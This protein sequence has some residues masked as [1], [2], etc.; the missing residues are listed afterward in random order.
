MPSPVSIS[1]FSKKDL[2]L[3]CDREALPLRGGPLVAH[4]LRPVAA[5]PRTARPP[6]W[7][8]WHHW[9]KSHDWEGSIP[10]CPPLFYWPLRCSPHSFSARRSRRFSI[11]PLLF[12]FC[13]DCSHRQPLSSRTGCC[14][15]TTD[16]RTFASSHGRFLSSLLSRCFPAL[17]VYLLSSTL[18]SR[19]PSLSLV[20]SASL[21][22]PILYLRLRLVAAA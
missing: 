6:R 18:L 4:V 19:I 16:W 8:R 11:R 3:F 14:S 17:L 20:S 7:L 9:A 22:Q 2:W 10:V 21:C 15:L 1:K 13:V 12:F 5:P